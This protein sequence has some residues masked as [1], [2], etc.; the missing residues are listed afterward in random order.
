MQVMVLND[1]ATYS[2]IRGCAIITLP[3]WLTS[4]EIEGVL[5]D[6]RADD[7]PENVGVRTIAAR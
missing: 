7:E 6:L 5:R 3:D 2:E 4:D 1:G